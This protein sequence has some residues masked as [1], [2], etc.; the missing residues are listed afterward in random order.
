MQTTAENFRLL[1][2]RQRV[3]V[4]PGCAVAAV[5]G[6]GDPLL[7]GGGGT[8]PGTTGDAAVI[9]VVVGTRVAVVGATVAAT[10][11]VAAAGAGVD[12]GA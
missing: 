11:A 9:A 3:G 1:P 12:A 6:A 2:L 10:V 4:G 7:G 8:L 5:A